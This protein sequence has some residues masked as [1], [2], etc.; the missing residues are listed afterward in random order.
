MTTGA[1]S[2]RDGLERQIEAALDPGYSVGDRDCFSFVED[3]EEVEREVA[4]LVETEPGR[5]VSLYEAFLAGCHE[6]AEEIDDSSG[7]FGDF[8]GELFCGWANARQAAGA[9][10]GETAA[11]LLGWM[12]DDP[13]GFCFRLE[14]DLAEVLDRAGLGALVEQVRKRFD[15]AGPRAEGPARRSRDYARRRWA[16]VLR[17]LH[18]AQKDIAAYLGVAEETGLTAADCHAVARMLVARRR[19]EE[20]LEWVERGIELEETASR[21]SLAGRDLADLRR[22]LLQRLGREQEALES[23]WAAYR[24]HP[25]T[26]TYREL[27]KFVPKADRAAWHEQAIQAAADGDLHSLIDLLLETKEIERLTELARRSD[28]QALE[29]VS[30][31]VLEPAAKKLERTDAAAAACLWRAMGMRIVNAGKSK[32]YDAALQNFAS[33]KRCYAATRLEADWEQVVGEVRAKHHRKYGFMPR[34]EQ[35]VSGSGPGEE[36]PFLE[37]AK[38]RWIGP[39]APRS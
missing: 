5:A 38:A 26:G 11:R 4:R 3:L 25:S 8:V 32:Y 20:A 16:E 31:Y 22:R 35:L 2:R 36:A 29:R 33:A 13:S 30:H 17:A 1:A 21:G 39:S 23:A 27:M 28:A 15:A 7:S 18:L 37:R 12:E 10:P 34:F 6:K 14:K 19:P 9:D 24:R